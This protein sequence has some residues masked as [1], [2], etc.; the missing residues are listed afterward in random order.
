MNCN[1]LTYLHGGSNLTP[2]EKIQIRDTLLQ[3]LDE[4]LLLQ[5]KIYRIIIDYIEKKSKNETSFRYIEDTYGKLKNKY[6]FTEIKNQMNLPFKDDDY[7]FCFIT[8][9]NKVVSII[10]KFSDTG[11]KNE[12]GNQYTLIAHRRKNLSTTLMEHVFKHLNSKNELGYVF[13]EDPRN[14]DRWKQAGFHSVKNTG[15]QNKWNGSFKGLN[16]ITYNLN[17]PTFVLRNNSCETLYVL[18]SIYSAPA[19]VGNNNDLLETQTYD[20]IKSISSPHNIIRI[21]HINKLYTHNQIQKRITDDLPLQKANFFNYVNEPFSEIKNTVLIMTGHGG[22]RNGEYEYGDTVADAT[23]IK[24]IYDN[25]DKRKKIF[26][27]ISTCYSNLAVRYIRQ[28]QP[29]NMAALSTTLF[30]A[31]GSNNAYLVRSLKYLQELIQK[32]NSNHHERTF[33]MAVNH[34]KYNQILEIDEI[35]QERYD[36]CHRYVQNYK[37]GYGQQ[38]L[39]KICYKLNHMSD[40]TNERIKN[41]V[42]Q[43]NENHI[44][45]DIQN[46]ESH[47]IVQLFINF[48]IYLGG[49]TFNLRTTNGQFFFAL[50]ERLQAY[51][52]ISLP[53]ATLVAMLREVNNTHNFNPI[54]AGARNISLEDFINVFKQFYLGVNHPS[55]ASIAESYVPEKMKHEIV[56][57]FFCTK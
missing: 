21:S 52:Q 40:L 33:E 23:P 34:M 25:L 26:I 7:I 44:Y 12:I 30:E 41:S 35:N 10:V 11:R 38:T 36:K 56:H 18:N 6:N 49:H 42:D 17:K 9:N 57:S 47:P 24:K 39:K 46:A 3:L 1:N 28:Q 50:F 51:N 45:W 32:P 16:H 14:K 37:P 22:E 53:L 2:E 19:G 48:V 13:T 54:R 29:Q 4:I 15:S 8:T 31:N 27:I 20:I 43:Y 55:G 5:E